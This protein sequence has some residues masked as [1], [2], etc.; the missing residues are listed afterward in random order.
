MHAVETSH[1]TR[2]RRMTCGQQSRT[3]PR[4]DTRPFGRGLRGNIRARDPIRG[5]YKEARATAGQLPPDASRPASQQPER[6]RA[7][8]ARGSASEPSRGRPGHDS[9]RERNRAFGATQRNSTESC[10]GDR[11]MHPNM[12][13]MRADPAYGPFSQEDIARTAK[14]IPQQH[15]TYEI[16]VGKNASRLSTSPIDQTV[17][18]RHRHITER[19]TPMTHS[20]P[21]SCEPT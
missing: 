7:H 5:R 13:A 19:I 4:S 11:A 6:Q 3:G 20:P 18:S 16:H 12:Q 21:A 2:Q 9:S 10:K 15:G 14:S 17:T 8:R 1:F